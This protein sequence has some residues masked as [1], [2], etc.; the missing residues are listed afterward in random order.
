MNLVQLASIIED[1]DST[2]KY[3]RDNNLLKKSLEH[4]GY[5]C[6]QV[7]EKNSTDNSFFRC[8]QCKRKFSIRTD[9]LFRKSKL[10]LKNLLLLIYLFSTGLSVTDTRK[11]LKDAVSERTIIQWY[12]YLREIC[13]LVLLNTPIT[14]GRNGSVIQIDEANIG[15]KRKYN[16][17]TKGV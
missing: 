10:T 4:C 14:L 6:Y 5:P 11:L 2:I 13:S 3:L 12:S 17:V 1:V 9:S 8:R 7:Q 15:A 16:R